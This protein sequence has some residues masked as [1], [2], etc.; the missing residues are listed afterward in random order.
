MRIVFYF[1]SRLPVGRIKKAFRDS[2]LA[3]WLCNIK[4]QK[5]WLLGIPRW[6]YQDE[7]NELAINEYHYAVPNEIPELISQKDIPLDG[8]IFLKADIIYYP[9]NRTAFVLSWNHILMDVK[10]IAM[11]IH[12]LN[13]LGSGNDYPM[14]SLFPDPEKKT[15]LLRHL[16]NMYA[17]KQFIETSSKAPITSIAGKNS[18]G[19][20]AFKNRILHFTA[21]ETATISEHAIR[22]GAAFGDNPYYLSCCSRAVHH[23]LQQRKQGGTL[24]I[25]IPYDGRLKGSLG[26]VISNSVAFIFYR[27][28]EKALTSMKEAVTCF[29]T[30]MT[31]QIKAKMP[32]KYGLLLNLMRHIPL[33]LYYFL[34]SQRGKGNFA[35]FLYSSAG[36]T[37]NGLTALFG[38]SVSSLT[39]FPSPTF[40][41]GLTFSFQK[42]REALNINIA[43]SPDIVEV[44]EINKIELDLKHFLLGVQP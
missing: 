2:P 31:E 16:K 20:A 19:K 3:Y 26:P 24:W 5:S 10:G 4:L 40:P 33:R 12:H 44:A 8:K 28:P 34:V 38:E 6:R 36:E 32:R 18:P 43:Y 17:V 15:G 1:N 7:G 29:S 13:E 30:Q 41:P 25:P 27:V 23:I 21:E 39:I 14:N 11:L 37:F 42:H 9:G 35:S 22:N